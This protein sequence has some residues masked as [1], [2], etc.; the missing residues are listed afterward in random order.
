MRSIALFAACLLALTG[1]ARAQPAAPNPVREMLEQLPALV[2]D[3]P[4]P[5]QARFLD[6][7]VLL[8]LGPVEGADSVLRR[9]GPVA[10]M[11]PLRALGSAGLAEWEE[12]AGTKLA[13]LRSLAMVDEVAV[14]WRLR[15]AAGAE[16]VMARL[17]QA[18]FT[19][20]EP[21]LLADPGPINVM[22]RMRNPWRGLRS[23]PSHVQRQGDRL[24][25][26]AGLQAVQQLSGPGEGPSAAA[27]T[28]P[29]LAL[30]GLDA[31]RGAGRIVQAVLFSPSL[32][33]Q[34]GD[35]AQALGLQG[36]APRAA[37][38]EGL[39]P[40]R[41]GLL[42][43]LDEAG[44]PVLVIA[45]A[46][47]DCALAEAAIARFRAGWEGWAT[48]GAPAPLPAAIT[49]RTV[50]GEGGCAAALRIAAGTAQGTAPGAANPALDRLWQA[51]Q[52]RDPTPLDI[53]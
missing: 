34:A 30:A 6:V 21:G 1:A 18:G 32:T 36:A 26:A 12:A 40:Y 25:Q 46:Y 43:D 10:E 3:N 27:A 24:V 2:A 52:R 4:A 48:P 28:A 11:V 45:L 33:L 19:E 17:R 41:Q 51:L 16:A 7:A 42:A 20:V 13:G 14:L 31:Q 35:P 8:S 15:D 39:P 22:Q 23:G 9:V 47:P 38:G 49:G 50:A 44:R 29:R 5:V 53:R 37:P